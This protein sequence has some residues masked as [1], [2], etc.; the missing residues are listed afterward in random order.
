M[1]L[2]EEGGLT[3]KGMSLAGVKRNLLLV[4][5]LRVDLGE[6]IRSAAEAGIDGPIHLVQA[7]RHGFPPLR[8]RMQNGRGI[9]RRRN[10][11]RALE[12]KSREAPFL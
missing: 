12:Q 1:T 7:A 6:G 11:R 4:H 10:G 5:G 2:K 9:E 3:N 8:H